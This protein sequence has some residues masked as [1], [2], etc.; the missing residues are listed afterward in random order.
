MIIG[1]PKEIKV[2]EYRVGLTPS[3]VK[4]YVAAGHTVYIEKDAGAAI[5][6]PDSEYKAAGAIITDKATLF[7]KAE[8]IIKVKEPI[9]PEYEYFKPNSTLYT[10]LHLAADKALTDMLLEKNITAIAYETIRAKD[11][12]LPC[13]APMSAIAGRLGAYAAG[14]YLQKTYGGSGVLLGGAPGIPKARVLIIGGG[15]VGINAAQCALGMGA[16]VTVLN[17]TLGKLVGVDHMFEMKVTTGISNRE[18]IL[19][20]L[21]EMDVVIGAALI[22]GEKAPKL[23]L[24]EDL[25]LMKKGSLLIDISIDQGGCFETSRATTHSDPIYIEEG[26]VH[27]CVANM[28]GC[29]A[30]SSTIALTDATISYGLEIA[31]KG[32][33]AA[34]LDND[35]LSHG[36]NCY[37]GSC[38]NL[39]VAHAFSLKYV[40]PLTALKG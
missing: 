17:T 20:L 33:K 12:S 31:A 23:I 29:V 32:A 3:N 21:P 40:E 13:L 27:Y 37:K 18:N 24:K 36:L 7:E 14:T 35:A 30:K 2:H 6:H 9:A 11:G 15:T 10:Y 22:V 26:I 1:C 19:A 16:D 38:T 25:K 4:A 34:L 28:P 39:G 8:M 5:N